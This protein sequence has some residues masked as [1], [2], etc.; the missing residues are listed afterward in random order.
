MLQT[1]VFSAPGVTVTI[2]IDTNPIGPGPPTGFDV[3]QPAL[4]LEGWA[5]T[6]IPTGAADV[7]ELATLGFPFDYLPPFEGFE[8]TNS[9]YVWSGAIRAPL[10]GLYTINASVKSGGFIEFDGQF[11]FDEQTEPNPGGHD[12]YHPSFTVLLKKDQIYPIK[13]E[14]VEH[15]NEHI[16]VMTWQTPGS[17]VQETIPNH[18]C[19][20]PV[21]WKTRI[22]AFV[23]PPPPPPNPLIPP[24]PDWPTYQSP[25]LAGIQIVAA[26]SPWTTKITNAPVD[27]LSAAIIARHATDHVHP[28]FGRNGIG[29][30]IQLLP[31]DTPNLAVKFDVPDESDPGSYLIPVAPVLENGG[32]PAG[33]YHYIGVSVNAA[34]EIFQLRQLSLGIWGGYAGVVWPLGMDRQRP[35]GWTSADASGMAMLPGL[36]RPEEVLIDGV[37]AH[38]I[39]FTSGLVRSAYVPPA[40]H[41]TPGGGNDPTLPPMGCRW[42]LKASFDV[43]GLGPQAK[44]VAQAMKDYG[45]LLADTGSPGFLFLSGTPDARWD[46]TDL[47]TLKT[48]HATDYEVILMGP[49]TTI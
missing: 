16:F 40:S 33:D 34:Y 46:D 21:D 41:L 9:C 48:I 35:A 36:V 24:Q 47:A 14:M 7:G 8:R 39:R 3:T 20:P 27:P 43:T 31:R 4:L 26:G 28:G 15:A 42:R 10:D 1:T 49:M 37:I 18:L 11:R 32:N 29:I 44:V 19:V 17:T 22:K 13:T 38:A 2:S 12:Q 45:M 23:P 30:P 5:H 25:S 6:V